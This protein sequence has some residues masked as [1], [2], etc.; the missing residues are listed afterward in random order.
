MS[1]GSVPPVARIE[2]QLYQ[3]DRFKNGNPS[4]DQTGFDCYDDLQRGVAKY[5]Q[6]NLN[7]ETMDFPTKRRES[8]PWHRALQCQSDSLDGGKGWPVTAGQS[9]AQR[10][11]SPPSEGNLSQEKHLVPLWT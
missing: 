1:S 3:A 4:F 7:C 6:P 9:H 8:P 5:P 11:N 10:V 2:S